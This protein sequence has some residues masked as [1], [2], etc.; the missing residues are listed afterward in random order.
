MFKELTQFFIASVPRE[1][2]RGFPWCSGKNY[3][4][5]WSISGSILCCINL[6]NEKSIFVYP[7]IYEDFTSMIISVIWSYAASAVAFVLKRLDEAPHYQLTATISRWNVCPSIPITKVQKAIADLLRFLFKVIDT[8]NMLR[9][10]LAGFY[11]V[12]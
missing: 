2:V 8:L 1:D 6:P 9:K 4:S 3:A 5:R 7:G 11:N 12:C 10:Y